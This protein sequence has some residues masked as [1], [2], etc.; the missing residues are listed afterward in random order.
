MSKFPKANTSIEKRA[1]S[2]EE[3]VSEALSELGIN[4][5]EAVIEVIKEPSKGFLGLGAKE[6]VV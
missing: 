3:A 6:A 2:V 5:T 4:E 1:K